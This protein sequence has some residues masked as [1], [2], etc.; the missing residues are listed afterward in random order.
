MSRALVVAV[1]RTVPWRAVGAGTVVGLLVV[2]LPRLLAGPPDAWLGLN[3]LRAAALAFALG[4]AFLLDDPA[5]RLTTPV[6]TRR[7]IRTGLRV[8]LVAPFAALWWA[9][10][11]A[12]L[13][14]EARPP[15]GA[16]ALEATATAALALAAAA[17]VVRFSDEPEP[18]P[19]VAAALLTLAVLAPTLLPARWDLFAAVGSP[20]WEAAH[21]RWAMVLGCAALIWA[22]CAPE[23]VRRRTIRRRPTSRPGTSPT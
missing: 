14:S 4:L 8:A 7:W 19:S 11:L 9:T 6:A 23:P 10:A 20:G 21:K 1:A 17:L 13:P 18:G 5:R 22:L 15:F 3:L 12:L 16:I 2:G